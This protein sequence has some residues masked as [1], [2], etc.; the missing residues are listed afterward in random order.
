MDR[1]V[2]LVWA[3]CDRD[4]PAG[5]SFTVEGEGAGDHLPRTA[6][7]RSVSGNVQRL[8]SSNVAWAEYCQDDAGSGA[9]HPDAAIGA[10]SSAGR[11]D[12]KINDFRAR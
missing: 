5:Q 12:I 1:G 9:R 3:K 11:D 6:G 7:R 8:P 4:V 10:R 2:R